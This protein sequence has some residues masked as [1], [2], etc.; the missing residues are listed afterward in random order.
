MQ[1]LGHVWPSLAV[2]RVLDGTGLLAVVQGRLSDGP[3]REQVERLLQL[4]TVAGV[5]HALGE[6]VEPDGRQDRQAEVR[7]LLAG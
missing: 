7:G 5:V 6:V 2:A 4:L 1:C 3:L